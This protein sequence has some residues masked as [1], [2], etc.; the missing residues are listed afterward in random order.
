[1]AIHKNTTSGSGLVYSTEHGRTCPNCAKPVAQCCCGQKKGSAK[2]DGVIRVS[3]ETKGRK[4]SGVT[5]ITGLPL[6]ELELAALAKQ[7]KQRCGSGGTVKNRIIEVQGDQREVVLA[8]LLRLGYQA[9]K[10]GG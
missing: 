6:A 10:A 1:M 8:E 3:R 4:G 9:K 5:L 2:G 7:L